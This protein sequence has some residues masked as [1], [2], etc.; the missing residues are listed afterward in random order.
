MKNPLRRFARESIKRLAAA[1]LLRD[2]CEFG[3]TGVKTTVNGKRCISFGT[4]NYL[5]LANSTLLKRAA[6]RA[7]QR[8]GSGSAS[9][10]L[11]AG[12]LDIHT[13][14][15]RAAADLKR[16]ESACLFPCGYMANVGAISSLVTEGDAIVSDQSNHASIIDGCRLSGA[17]IFVYPH[18]EMDFLERTLKRVRHRFRKVLVVTESVFSVDGDIAPLDV[19]VNLARKYEAI[20]MLDDAHATGVLGAH[21][22]GAEELFNIEGQFDIVMGAFGKALGSQGGFVAAEQS[23]VKYLT[24]SARTFIYTTA[25]APPATAAALTAIKALEKEP[26][27]RIQLFVNVQRLGTLLLDRG[28]SDK[29]PCTPIVPVPVGRETRALKLQ[30]RLL[31]EGIFVPVMRYPTVPEGKAML[32]VSLSCLHSFA[33]IEKLFYALDRHLRFIH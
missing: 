26:Q 27:R 10:R 4:N 16:R 19:I 7:A 22:R 21:G 23:V 28:L 32:R 33:N 29:S 6:S 30:K 13:K 2:L 8:Y 3:S 15:E 17:K 20:T 18:C 9:S 25:L 11:V 1:G 14:L 31:E 24:N 12:T 5:G